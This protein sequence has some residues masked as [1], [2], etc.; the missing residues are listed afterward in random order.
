MKKIKSNIKKLFL[1]I[2]NK[3]IHLISEQEKK[4]NC[5]TEQLAS[6]QE[7]LA[8][9]KQ[10]MN[11]YF[12]GHY[13]TW[14]EKRVTAIIEYFSPLWFRGKK[15]LELGAGYG[16]IG[17]VFTA[18]GAE[19]TCSDARIEHLEVVKMKYPQI[20]TVQANIENEWPFEDRYDLILHLGVLYHLDDVN[21]SL[22][23]S[24][25]SANHV[26]L[27]TE[28][29]DSNDRSTILK[30]DEDKNGY[31]QS[32]TGRGSRPS[33]TYLENF[34]EHRGASFERI[35]GNECNSLFHQYNWTVQ[36]SGEWRHG[37]RRFWFI[38]T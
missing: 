24:L 2:L 15:I 7:E 22:E 31:D 30:V 10:C 20:H 12:R 11:H 27:E 4:V 25:N 17:A 13:T 28:V 3:E 16:D 21:F 29:C 5:L 6:T 1:R 38:K 37:L 32:F 18:L 35:A 36:N 8:Q 26:V 23:R 34:I 19:V 33:A 9:L 14:Q